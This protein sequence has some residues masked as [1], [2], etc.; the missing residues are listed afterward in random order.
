MKCPVFK[1]IKEVKF[2][3]DEIRKRHRS[4]MVHDIRE[5]GDLMVEVDAEVA[6]AIEN[7]EANG[8]PESVMA[9][10]LAEVSDEERTRVYCRRFGYCNPLLLKK[11]SEDENFG[12]LPKLIDLNEDYAIM[13]AAKFRKKPHYRNDPELSMGRPPW[14]RVYVD[15]TGGGMSMGCESYE[16]AIGSYLFVCSSTGEIHH[17]LYA[18]H[19]QF[20]A[21]LFQFLVHVGGEGNRC[22]EIYCDTFAVNIS[23]EVEEVA[24]MFMVKVIPV[25]AETP[26][27]VSFVETANRVIAG[28]SRAMLLGAPHLPKWCWELADKH[29]GLVGRLL[30]QST[31]GWKCSYY[32][33][34]GKAP[35]WHH[36][37]VHVFGAPC[38][39]SPMEGPVHKRAT[40]TIEE[41]YVGVQHPMALV[42][43]KSDMKL[44]SVSKKKVIVYESIMYVAPLSYSSERLGADIMAR[45]IQREREPD[46]GKQ[47]PKHLQ[48]TKSVS[49]HNIPIPNTT[50]PIGM[51][52]PT[53]PDERADTQSPSQGEGV[54]V[55]EHIGYNDD[56][57]SGILALK[58]KAQSTISDPGIRRKVIDSITNLQEMSRHGLLRVVNS[59][60]VRRPMP[61]L[62]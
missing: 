44:I 41:Y 39:F 31:R 24:A 61:K 42:L 33:N 20:P 16:G 9:F 11:M 49:A 37:F 21:A 10:N 27:E 4:A 8:L 32:L 56:L 5:C 30:P 17:K 51:R 19:E 28:R 34:T 6:E 48:S 52:A 53:R 7:V 15:G 54:I 3:V 22:H 40:Q 23:S 38:V 45:S 59:K 60:E 43:Q 57:A 18:R 12:K 58:E 36:M 55:P 2:I 46:G 25:S 62:T 13:D 29:A 35:Y 14:F 50:A 1:S 26:Q 47:W